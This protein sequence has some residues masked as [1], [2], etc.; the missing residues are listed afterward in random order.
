VLVAGD[1]NAKSVD[2]GSP[3]TD[4]R[5]QELAEWGAELGPYLIVRKKLRSGGLRITE[6]LHP[7]VLEDVV[8]ALFPHNGGGTDHPPEQQVHVVPW[9]DDLGIT[10]EELIG[11]IRRLRAKNTAPGP[12]GIPGR[13]WVLAL[14]VLGDRLRR[15]FSACLQT[16]QFPP[17]W[18]EATLV[19]LHKEGRP[20][21]S[22]SA[23]RPI[24]LLDEAGKLFERVLVA[25]L[26]RHLSGVG[27]DLADCQYG[28]ERVVPRWTRSTAFE[29]SRTSRSPVAGRRWRYRWISPTL[30]TPCHGSA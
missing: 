12:D 11:A 15:L 10:E 23:Y 9:T 28:P 29:P 8:S 6:S 14:G 1:L 26:L 22:P 5:G 16:G 24:C 20:V 21:E 18:K 2:W 25:R 30:S 19:L 4:A 7:Q 17:E 3:A 27:L 13:A